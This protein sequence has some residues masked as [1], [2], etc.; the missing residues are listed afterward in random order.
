MS[1]SLT[2]RRAA[3]AAAAAANAESREARIAAAE[4]AT[5]QAT[6][7]ARVAVVVALR[8]DTDDQD[9]V[10]PRGPHRRRNVSPS[11]VR[12]R[13]CHHRHGSP[14]V[15]QRVIKESGGSM[16]WPMLTKMNY[17]DWSLLMKVKLQ[18]RQLW[19]A[20][21]FSDVE[22][23]ED[24]LALDAFLSFV[25]SEMVASLADKPTVKDAWDSIATTRVGLDRTRPRKGRCRSCDKSGIALC[26]S[27]GRTSMTSLSVSPAWCNSW[28]GTTTTTSMST[29]RWR[30]IFAL[31]PRST[32]RSPC[33]W[34]LSW[35]SRPCPSRR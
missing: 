19:D 17:N 25:L 3:V 10:R 16:S 15:V 14:P 21:E 8:E 11:P 6:E 34:R 13:G 12:R 22:F 35:T 28:R 31:P 1:T 27:L 26:S 18:A 4:P 2:R 5:Q 32:L 7:T 24:R 9:G 23:H 20:V 30:S 29:S 33:Q